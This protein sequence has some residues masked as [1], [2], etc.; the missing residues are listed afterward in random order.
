MAQTNI[1][2]VPANIN[3]GTAGG[4]AV[5]YNYPDNFY[6]V[7]DPAKDIVSNPSKLYISQIFPDQPRIPLYSVNS[8]MSTGS[9]P[10]T[11]VPVLTVV[12]GT[13]QSPVYHQMKSLLRGFNAETFYNDWYPVSASGI[14]EKVNNILVISFANNLIGDKLNIYSATEGRF[15]FRIDNVEYNVYNYT[16]PSFSGFSYQI[17]NQY[18]NEVSNFG[19]IYANNSTNPQNFKGLFF[20]QLGL[21][22][23]YTQSSNP[24]DIPS[25]ITLSNAVYEENL[26]SKTFFCRITNEKYNATTN[27]TW[28]TYSPALGTNVIR[29][30]VGDS[31]H[32]Y[33][34]ITGIGLYNDQGQ[35]LA[36]AKLSR[37][38]LKLVDTELHARVVIQY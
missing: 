26:N 2:T 25:G 8:D 23:F 5:N 37:P 29:E 21:M 18:V 1:T 32:T 35:L 6:T 11:F 15:S 27:P 7:F 24:I 3:V 30:E 16:D 17:H 14:H 33:T 4:A 28:V 10:T 13:S 38:V 31:G 22:F 20:G 19:L 9:H 34:A 36:I 12:K